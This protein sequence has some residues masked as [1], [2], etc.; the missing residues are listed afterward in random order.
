MNEAETRAE[1][2]DPALLKAGWG[3]VEGS[4]I[5]REFPIT[6]GRLEGGVPRDGEGYG[7]FGFAG[8]Q[9]DRPVH[10]GEVSGRSRAS[11]GGADLE[12]DVYN[13]E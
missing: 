10:G 9:R 5:K 7:H 8:R 1:L 2:I 3:R 4:L 6:L 12:G 13:F 11:I